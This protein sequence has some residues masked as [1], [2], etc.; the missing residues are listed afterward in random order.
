MRHRHH[1]RRPLYPSAQQLPATQLS[2]GQNYDC[3]IHYRR[4][5]EGLSW[6]SSTHII[7][8]VSVLPD[9]NIRSPCVVAQISRAIRCTY[10]R[11]P[12]QLFWGCQN[13]GDEVGRRICRAVWHSFSE[14]RKKPKVFAEKTFHKWVSSNCSIYINF[15]VTDWQKNM[16][17]Q[18]NS[19]VVIV[20]EQKITHQ[21]NSCVVIVPEQKE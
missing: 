9:E 17:H 21:S 6:F 4:C 20:P 7:C 18:S 3:H 2:F 1:P 16:T 8:K 19:C 10:T 12:V 14:T 13:V 11:K 15:F 5:K